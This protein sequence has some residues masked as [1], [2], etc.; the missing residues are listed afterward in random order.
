MGIKDFFTRASTQAPRNT[1]VIVGRMF[2]NSL[3]PTGVLNGSTAMTNSDIY[4]VVNL[5]SSDLASMNFHT[6][7]VPIEN[8]LN[9]PNRLTNQFTFWQSVVAQLLLYGNSYVLINKSQDLVTGFEKLDDSQIQQVAISDDGQ[10][11]TYQVH[12][13]D[14]RPDMYYDS[15]ELLHFKLITVGDNNQSES[16][17]GK[18]PLISLVPELSIQQLTNRLSENTLKNAINPYVTIKIPEAKLDKET[19]DNIRNSFIEGTTGDNYG[20]PVVL[21]SSADL[22]TIGV[23]PEVTNLLN[24]L[25]WT[26]TQVSKAFGV[27][28]SYLMGQGDAQS[29]IEMIQDLYRG[30]IERYRNAVTAELTMKLGTPISLAEQV[31][32]DAEI[33]RLLLLQQNQVITPGDTKIALQNRGII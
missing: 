24:N 15:S 32:D 17:F 5:V 9:N 29:N 22:G 19:K 21:D 1:G 31:T 18:S 33:A 23:S 30:S 13:Y 7:N 28:D 11:L 27:P 8:A 14:S 16:I 26:K 4:S 25:N 3:L 12:F 2:G 6:T 10:A 20:K